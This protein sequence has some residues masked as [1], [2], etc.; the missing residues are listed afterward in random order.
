MIESHLIAGG[1]QLQLVVPSPYRLI[2]SCFFVGHRVGMY[3]FVRE[4]L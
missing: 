1:C 2:H 4:A 3:H